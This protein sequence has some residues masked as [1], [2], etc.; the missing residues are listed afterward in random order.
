M[1]RT[2]S[3]CDPEALRRVLSDR[4]VPKGEFEQVIAHLDDCGACRAAIEGLA[5]GREW[6]DRAREFVADD[7]TELS[8]L[9]VTDKAGSLGR[10]GP[11]EVSGVLGRGGMGVVLLARD[12][13][14]DRPVAIKVLSPAIRADAQAR[15]RF[16]REA[17]AAAAVVH[18]HVVAI[19]AVDHAAGLPYLV[20][21]Y[22]AGKSL[23]DRIDRDGPLRVEEILRIG[24]QVA[25]G[26]AGAHAQGLV[27]RDIKPANILLENGVERV[28]LTDFGLARA[29]DDSALT[30]SGVVAGTPQY[31]SPEQARGEPVDHRT[32]LFSLGSVLY[33]MCAGRPP[34]RADSTPALLKRICDDQPTSVQ[35]ANADVP[36]WLADIIGRLLAKNPED[37]YQTSAE[38]AQILSRRLATLQET[39]WQN[40]DS[41]PQTE[42]AA[43]KSGWSRRETVALV[44]LGGMIAGF[45]W[46]RMTRRA[47][48][49]IE[50]SM[51]VGATNP[52]PVAADSPHAF[53]PV[54]TIS[55]IVR[56]RK[57]GKPVPGVRLSLP[58]TPA[59]CV[60]DA[61]GRYELR[62]QANAWQ[63]GEKATVPFEISVEPG[64]LPYFACVVRKD[65]DAN[66]PDIELSG[67][68]PFRIRLIDD[69]T[70]EP[71]RKARVV[72]RP[73]HPNSDVEAMLPDGGTDWHCIASEAPNGVYTGVLVRG[74][75][76]IAVESYVD[77]YGP[78]CVDPVPF[79]APGKTA[80]EVVDASTVFGT[81]GL[82]AVETGGGRG[83][84]YWPQDH[85]SA[86]LLINPQNANSRVD[87]E[88]SLRHNR[89][90]K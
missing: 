68:I 89:V 1:T 28:K 42:K 80:R 66:R 71:I 29:V 52:A 57:T 22:I 20:M 26:L 14:L 76:A 41:I 38:V 59:A 83:V 37:R 17:R 3:P 5:A 24:M 27:H 50:P 53:G 11:Y 73:L 21:Q 48:E 51:E 60:T 82:L 12:P 74:P 10:L 35:Q 47:S 40:L 18:E 49:V 63:E 75:G 58:R 39:G 84:Y 55:G 6:W 36:D 46:T 8:F 32:D 67:G 85:M 87:Q 43:K 61:E 72:Y 90:R 30:L 19:H 56:D 77:F 15:Q 33:A 13:A 79:F 78:I 34:F 45:S 54:R 86:L 44:L 65:G 64:E 16:A 31:M 69:E 7:H 88:L 9:T 2:T 70:N 23:Q 62:G 81:K 25:S 4:E